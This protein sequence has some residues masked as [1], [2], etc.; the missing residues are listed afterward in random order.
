M[1][2]AA[3]IPIRSGS[4]RLPKKNYLFLGG[5]PI[6]EHVIKKVIESNSFSYV[7]INTEDPDLEKVAKKYNIGFYLRPMWLA[8]ATATSDQ[9]VL[10]A[11]DQIPG[12]NDYLFW[13]NTASPLTTVGDIR[14]VVRTSIEKNPH[15]IVTVRKTRGHLVY[16]DRPVNFSMEGGFARTQDMLHAFE[17]NYAIMG[18]SRTQTESLKRRILFSETTMLVES[19]FWSNILLKTDD[20]FRIIKTIYDQCGGTV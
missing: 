4:E 13:V 5:L 3:M 8:S 15:A 9:V 12:E 6:Y 14:D 11:F 20:D 17:F 16:H 1:N 10:D 18:W 7:F 19:S 2:C